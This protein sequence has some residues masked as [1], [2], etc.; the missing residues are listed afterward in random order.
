MLCL[1]D[2][3]ADVRACVWTAVSAVTYTFLFQLIYDACLLQQNVFDDKQT[4]KQNELESCVIVLVGL[5][6]VRLRRRDGV[7]ATWL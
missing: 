3:S 2:V 7:S 1:V 6:M 4:S 5:A